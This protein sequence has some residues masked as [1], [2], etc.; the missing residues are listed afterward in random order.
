MKN[1][2]VIGKEPIRILAVDDNP[3]SLRLLESMLAR[4]KDYSVVTAGHGREALEYLYDNPEVVDIV[5]LDRMMPGMDGIE[6]CE[7]IKAD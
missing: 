1:F 3:A 2:E 4:G 7:V 6:V 5:L